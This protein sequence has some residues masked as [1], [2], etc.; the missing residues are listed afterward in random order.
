MAGVLALAIS[1]CCQAQS[2]PQELPDSGLLRHIVTMV[3]T[4]F[5]IPPDYDVQLG[6]RAPSTTAGY[7]L[8]PISISRDGKTTVI[9]FLISTDGRTL[10]KLDTFDL[11]ADLAFSIDVANRPMRGNPAAKVTVVNFDD[12]ECPVCSHLHQTLFPAI[13][14]R[15]KDK[16]RF[17]YRDNPLAEL[18]PWGV[19][20]SVDANCLAAQNADAYWAF[21]DYLHTHGQEV[22]VPNRDLAKSFAAL[23]RIARQGATLAS[24]DLGRL[25]VCLAR[26]DEAQVRASMKDAELLGL[27]FAPA[28]FVNGERISGFV[29]AAQISRVIDR[30]LH[31]AGEEPPAAP[32]HQPGLTD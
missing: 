17:V 12:L 8:L 7:D 9:E 29:P 6:R 2:A 4:K 23:D 22:N 19:H 24:L 11:A 26:Q 16:V 27:D 32:A 13:L 28:L 21:V 31:D 1:A 25:D 10:A 3:R 14:D 20:A 30:A 18:H 15:Y 5:S